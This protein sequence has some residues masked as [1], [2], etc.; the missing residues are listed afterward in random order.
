MDQPSQLGDPGVA[1]RV[2]LLARELGRRTT[3]GYVKMAE[4]LTGSIGEPFPAL[5]GELLG[6]LRDTTE[7]RSARP[8][9]PRRDWAKVRAKLP[10]APKKAVRMVGEAGFAGTPF[11]GGVSRAIRRNRGELAEPR[12]A[13]QREGTGG[14]GAGGNW[15]AKAS[16]PLRRGGVQSGVQG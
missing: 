7:E 12:H 8:S 13:A 4:D 5:P 2:H 10:R 1:V 16:T 15:E 9:A 11:S 3:L 6:A 14:D